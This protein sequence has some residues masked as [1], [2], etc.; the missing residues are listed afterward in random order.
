MH[1][2]YSTQNDTAKWIQVTILSASTANKRAKWITKWIKIANKLFE[3]HDF[4]TLAAIHGALTSQPIYRQN[5]AWKKVPAKYC[6]KFEEFKVIYDSRG[7]H[8]N[9][10][11]IHRETPLPMVAYAG[12]LLQ[13][14]FQ[15]DE[16]AKSKEKDGSVNFSKLMRL[17]AAVQ[18]ITMIKQHK[19]EIEKNE[20]MER[21]L[22]N[23]LSRY[24]HLT[25]DDVYRKSTDA[26]NNDD[27][28]RQS[29]RI[30]HLSKSAKSLF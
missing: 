1:H 2:D 9:L 8:A 6:I 7:N 12:V 29:S 30:R 18:R 13:V 17:H 3:A 15:I 16:G 24:A 19:Y 21:F 11:K 14:L 10:R 26:L 20:K 23:C 4:Q 27:P 25:G 28:K 5:A 22:R